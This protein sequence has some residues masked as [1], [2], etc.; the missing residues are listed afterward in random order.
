M[1]LDNIFNLRSHLKRINILRIVPKQLAILLQFLDKHVRQRWLEL[2]RID[3]LG[4][5]EKRPRIVIKVKDVE[6]GLWIW[7]VREI[8]A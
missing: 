3:L 6:H 7:Q 1:A 2:S 4:K 5:L 8:H